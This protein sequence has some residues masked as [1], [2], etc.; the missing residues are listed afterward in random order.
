MKAL[1]ALFGI[2]GLLMIVNGILMFKTRYGRLKKAMSWEEE[3][4]AR[5]LAEMAEGE[6]VGDSEGDQ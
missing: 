4:L 6:G 3:K 5:E 1:L 2:F